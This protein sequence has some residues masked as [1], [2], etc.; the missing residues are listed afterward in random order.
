[1]SIFSTESLKLKDMAQLWLSNTNNV[2]FPI[3][4]QDNIIDI[5]FN[6]FDNYKID[7]DGGLYVYGEM[8][9]M[10]P[11][12]EFMKIKHCHKLFI[13]PMASRCFN[14]CQ[15]GTIYNISISFD[16]FDFDTISDLFI[17]E[18]DILKSQQTWCLD[19]RRL[20]TKILF[21]SDITCH[22]IILPENC[23]AIV[24]DCAQLSSITVSDGT[25]LAADNCP[26]L[27]NIENI[28]DNTI[29]IDNCPKMET[30]IEM[31]NE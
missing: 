9:L 2:Y 20:N 26:K 23:T 3:V 10:S 17:Q 7:D 11:L 25:L 8:V 12:P 28:H 18:V 5:S 14:K 13:A 21:I 31:K 6:N 15:I 22:D 4:R 24:K 19:L 16:Y 30:K 1:M 27:T 29:R